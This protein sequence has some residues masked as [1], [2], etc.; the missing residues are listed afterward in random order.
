MAAIKYQINLWNLIYSQ[1]PMHVVCCSY[2]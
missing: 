2:L 1:P